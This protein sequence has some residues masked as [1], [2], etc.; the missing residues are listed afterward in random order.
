MKNITQTI[1]HHCIDKGDNVYSVKV[2][3]FGDTFELLGK[4]KFG[5]ALF[6]KGKGVIKIPKIHFYDI[7]A[8]LNMPDYTLD[9]YKLRKLRGSL[10]GYIRKVTNKK[11]NVTCKICLGMIKKIENK[12]T[13]RE[14]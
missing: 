2:G 11:E 8:E 10:C 5:L 1:G 12:S 7:R 6:I 3:V 4:A 14:I 13:N 9:E